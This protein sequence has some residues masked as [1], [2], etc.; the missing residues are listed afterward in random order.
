[1]STT[2]AGETGVGPEA[3]ALGVVTVVA[4]ASLLVVKLG[5]VIAFDATGLDRS[6]PEQTFTVVL[7]ALTVAVVP[8]A[9]AWYLYGRRTALLGGGALLVVTAVVAAMLPGV[10]ACGPSC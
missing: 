6:L 10:G 9:L 7:P 1:M 2:D 5:W 4:V 8:A 3:V